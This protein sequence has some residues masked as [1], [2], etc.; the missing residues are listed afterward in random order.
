MNTPSPLNLSN[1]QDRI[2]RRTW[3]GP[4]SFNAPLDPKTGPGWAR[5]VVNHNAS[6]SPNR[7]DCS[8]EIWGRSSEPPQRMTA[9]HTLNSTS[10]W[11]F[12]TVTAKR[13]HSQPCERW[14]NIHVDGISR[15]KK[16]PFETA[17]FLWAAALSTVRD[18]IVQNESTHADVLHCVL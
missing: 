12:S 18:M 15:Y 10:T 1:M 5:S 2:R 16:L 14:S 11:K 4:M 17:H 13:D 6:P 8:P 3:G 9:V 7:W